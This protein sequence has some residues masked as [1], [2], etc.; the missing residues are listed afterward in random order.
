MAA[1]L[2]GELGKARELQVKLNPLH[3]ALFLES[4]P[5]PVKWGL[6]LMKRFGPELRL[7]LVA[8]TEPHAATLK[9]V[10]AKLALL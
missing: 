4:N 10:L 2:G 6:Y 1:A 3:H 5:I 9:S 7:P 8:M